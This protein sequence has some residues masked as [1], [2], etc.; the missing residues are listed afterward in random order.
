MDHE[1]PMRRCLELARESLANG[2]VPVGAVVVR[3]GQIIAEGAER[4]R[5]LL[6]HTAHAEVRA[7]HAACQALQSTSLAGLTLYSTVEPCV[8]CAYVVRR[9]ALSQVVYGIPA[10]Q[11]GGHTSRYALL[12]DASLRG[13]PPPPVVVSGVLAAE[14][15]DLMRQFSQR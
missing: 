7:I 13:W 5:A 6:D 15:A 4:T 3:D 2:E 8:L 12:N 11:A 9:A 10:G 1:S 14:C